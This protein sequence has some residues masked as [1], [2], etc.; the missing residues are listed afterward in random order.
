VLD[1]PMTPGQT[2]L[3]SKRGTELCV[4]AFY[5]QTL[6]QT[7]RI[8]RVESKPR[9]SEPPKFHMLRHGKR[10]AGPQL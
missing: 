8:A 7:S 6:K 3:S 9:D 2:A 10:D 1:L 4:S 5:T